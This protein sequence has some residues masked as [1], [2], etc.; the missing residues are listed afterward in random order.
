MCRVH[1]RRATWGGDVDLLHQPTMRPAPIPPRNLS[2]DTKPELVQQ[3][4]SVQSVGRRV[5]L[6]TLSKQ[7]YGL[8]VRQAG[9]GSMS[10]ADS[11]GDGWSWMQEVLEVTRSVAQRHSVSSSAV[12]TAWVLHQPQARADG[13]GASFLQVGE[14]FC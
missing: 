5:R 1:V 12:A 6:D 4:T 8:I 13:W 11:N 9:G 2:C 3:A 7:K 10:R 14:G